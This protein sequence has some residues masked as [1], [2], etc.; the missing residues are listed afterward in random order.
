MPT[1]STTWG[2]PFRSAAAV[3]PSPPAAAATG[4]SAGT[5]RWPHPGPDALVRDGRGRGARRDVGPAADHRD[6]GAQPQR[7]HLPG[8]GLPGRGP[9]RRL[10]KVVAGSHE[11]ALRHCHVGGWH[12]RVFGLIMLEGDRPWGTRRRRTPPPV[13]TVEVA[14]AREPAASARTRIPA[15]RALELQVGMREQPWPLHVEQLSMAADR[16]CPSAFLRL[17]ILGFE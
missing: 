2:T 1:C 8:R 10:H 6:R 3:P 14:A 9:Q 13:V 15:A 5:P 12:G 17:L 4:G 16:W 7:P 11:R